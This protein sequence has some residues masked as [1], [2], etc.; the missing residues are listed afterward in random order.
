MAACGE[1]AE[2]ARHALWRMRALQQAHRRDHRQPVPDPALRRRRDR[3]RPAGA[4]RRP[5]R[6]GRDG[7]HGAL[8]LLGQ[9][10]GI[11]LR[12]VAAVR[13]EQP[14]DEL[15]AAVRRRQRAAQRP[16]E[17][18]QLH[19][20][21][22]G[23]HRRTDG[24][25]V[26][27]GAQVGRRH[28]GAQVPDR[29]LRRHD[30]LQARRR[31]AAA[32]RRRHLSGAGEGHARR[33]RMGRPLRRREARLPEGREVLLLPRLVGRLRAGPQH[34][35]PRQVERA[36]EAL[37]GRDHDGVG[38]DLGV[39]ARQVRRRQSRPPSSA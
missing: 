24:R 15:L 25:L 39:G 10:P 1:L 6:H 20:L 19:R 3:P 27:Q 12:H 29:R 31:A 18:L 35:Q 32:C 26:P 22:G 37:P 2:V 38:R 7:Q 8:L 36:A 28:E 21:R 17:E 13:S 34:H 5:E 9:G 33:V 23:Q 30:R 4:R 11:D 16:A 14:A